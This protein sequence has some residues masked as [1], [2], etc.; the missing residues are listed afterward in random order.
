M[1]SQPTIRSALLMLACSALLIQLS[2][3]GD[4]DRRESNVSDADIASQEKDWLEQQVNDYT[5]VYREQCFC[6]DSGEI[7]VVVRDG[8]LD[9]ATRSDPVTGNGQATVSNPQTIN[10]LFDL[11][12][13]AQREADELKVRFDSSL[14][15]PDSISIDWTRD[16][17]DEE[18]GISVSRLTRQ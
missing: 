7:T 14:G 10:A 18:Y 15:Y 2:G 4:S 9:R 17:V 6:P 12:R 11:V 8:K 1:S 5:L 16:A 3:C 13:R